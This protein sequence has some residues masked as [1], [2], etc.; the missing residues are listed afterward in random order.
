MA[1]KKA[2]SRPNLPQEV[3][4][5][6]RR[7]A[8]GEIAYQSTASMAE[9]KGKKK[10]KGSKTAAAPVVQT[11]VEDLSKEYAY[12]ITDLRNMGILAAALFLILII[13]SFF[14]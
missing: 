12:V 7:E 1:R 11:T 10:N 4:D 9:S 2:S 13:M 8:S 6:A 5:R 14:L 3:L